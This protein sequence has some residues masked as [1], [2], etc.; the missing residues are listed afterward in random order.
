MYT[1]KITKAGTEL[2]VEEAVAQG[3]ITV[4][5]NG[6]IWL[7]SDTNHVIKIKGDLTLA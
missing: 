5:S 2:T 3:L 6:D 4:D 1:G 7:T